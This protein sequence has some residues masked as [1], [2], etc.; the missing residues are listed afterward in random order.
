MLKKINKGL[1]NKSLLLS[2]YIILTILFVVVPIFFIITKSLSPT[3]DSVT[4]EILDVSNNWNFIDK[5]I[6]EKIGLSFGI[7]IAS[8]IICAIFGYLFAYFLSLSKNKSLKIIAVC[9]ITSPM[10][11]STLIKLVGL[12]TFFDLMNGSPNSTYG[13]IYTI[14]ALSYINFPIFILT[15][16]TYI[17][18]I[19]KNLL[20]A[21]KDLGKSS[22]KTFFCVVVPYTKN[23][24]ISGILLVFL[25]SLTN[26]G[27]T[28]FVNNSNDGS[29]IGNDLL[30]QGLESSS[31]QIALARVSSLS[32]LICLLIL[33]LWSIFVLIPKAIKT[34]KKN[35]E[36]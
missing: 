9:L 22:I 34:Y 32:L 10:W 6:F 31:S 8:T 36:K 12:K 29:I 26:A 30:N 25:P 2:P 14:L 13:N 24:I 18:S 11:I 33:L 16:Y 7:S 23:A 4:S 1:L 17:N 3:K 5:T 27:V 20:Q 35:K 21:S 28:Q 15:I 19:P